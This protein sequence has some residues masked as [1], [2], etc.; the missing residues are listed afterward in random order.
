MSTSGAYGKSVFINAPFDRSRQE[1]LRATVFA[2]VACGC[3]P[4]C[5]LEIEDSSS[6]RIQKI[7]DLIRSCACGIHDL[8]FMELDPK[9]RLPRFNMPFE[10]GLF[11]GAKQFGSGRQ[12]R[13]HCLVLDSQRHR[14]Q[15]SMS[16]IAGQDIACHKG[17]EKG[18]IT[19]IGKWLKSQSPSPPEIYERYRMFKELLP[20]LS[21]KEF[22][23]AEEQLT[24]GDYV[25]IVYWWLTLK[26]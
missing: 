18:V 3:N 5:A 6:P 11:L 13:K 14:Y 15:K 23:V 25:R 17:T 20:R 7:A 24:Y 22:H 21:R 19:A 10:L 1:L 9:T 8:S 2:A 26:R 16:D 12:K 4:R